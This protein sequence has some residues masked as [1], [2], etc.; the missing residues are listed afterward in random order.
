MGNK[1]GEDKLPVENVVG[2]DK[3]PVGNVVGED[4]LLVGNEV[5]A[6]ECRL[7]LGLLLVDRT[8]STIATKITSSSPTTNAN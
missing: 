4:K 2:T 6:P 5:G 3:F 7:S 1:V 8:W